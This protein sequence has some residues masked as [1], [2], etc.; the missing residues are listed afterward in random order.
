MN[1]IAGIFHLDGQS[2][3][4]EQLSPMLDCLADW[5]AN[6]C[7]VQVES[8]AG[9]GVRQF[10][11]TREDERECQPLSVDGKYVLVADVRLDNCDE[12]IGLLELKACDPAIL[13]D[14]YLIVKAYERWGEDAPN[15]LIGDF[16]FALWDVKAR[17]LFC[18]RD[19]MGVKPF[20]YACLPGRTFV[21]GS[22]IRML[23]A[24]GISKEINE[25]YLGMMMALDHSD[26]ERTAFK[27]VLRL[28]GGHWLSVSR[29]KLIVR[30]YWELERIVPIRY[31]SEED[32]VE[33]LRHV[34][35]EAVKCRLRGI[36]PIGA[37]LSGGLDSSSVTSVAAQLLSP[38]QRLHSFSYVFPV[39]AE[40]SKSIDERKYQQ[41]VVERYSNIEHHPVVCDGLDPLVSD[42]WSGDEPRAFYNFFLDKAVFDEACACGVR[43]L[44]TGHDGDAAVSHGYDIL[45][46]MVVKWRL[47]AFFRQ[48]FALSRTHGI[49]FAKVI[50]RMG[51]R[52]Y[53]NFISER[54]RLRRCSTVEF[55]QAN[56]L[57]NSVFT[58][59]V[60]LSQVHNDAQKAQNSFLELVN[61][62][63]NYIRS[64]THGNYSLLVEGLD[65]HTRP[66]RLEVRHPF[67]DRRF[68]EYSLAIP[69]DLK[70]RNGVSRYIMHQAMR[71]IL[72]DLVN[73]R[74]DKA[75]LSACFNGGIL[76]HA[77]AYPSGVQS[78]SR[79]RVNGYVD[80]SYCTL[81]AR[82]V[83]A[84]ET[85]TDRMRMDLFCSIV[86]E[87]W[88]EVRN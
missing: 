16:A 77:V 66:R 9:L 53:R 72:P 35:N 73:D 21:F 79:Q 78:E 11:M 36:H 58:Q 76:P 80:E 81:A 51:L 59:R 54:I 60:G 38:A 28:P 88:L 6:R 13:T 71:G 74:L 61:A 67:F 69:Q 47:L 42:L 52:P 62:R 39:T 46:E 4:A 49:R 17:R 10:F 86:L 30:R 24:G 45:S 84:S 1:E 75:N 7:D 20:Y 57:V 18:A 65:G 85:N 48:C 2:A 3:R 23:L 19:A 55:A 43:V 25:L 32:Y 31:S 15:R 29:D 22:V 40:F 27:E 56:P 34:F 68:V 5:P 87:H 82:K 63:F 12:L 26:R 8:S 83:V 44:L 64:I 70:L 41:A 37:Q 33:G 50:W 14:G